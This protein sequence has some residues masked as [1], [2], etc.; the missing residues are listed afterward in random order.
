MYADVLGG[1]HRQGRVPRVRSVGAVLRMVLVALTAIGAAN[2]CFVSVAHAQNPILTANA[3]GSLYPMAYIDEAT[4]PLYPLAPYPLWAWQDARACL[5]EHGY[6]PRSA[7]VQMP[8]LRVVP[9]A[10]TFRVH[11]LTI[12]SLA[13]SMDTT[14]M[15]SGFGAPTIGYSLLHSDVVIITSAYATNLRVL[16]HEAIHFWLWRTKKLLGHPDPQFQV[17]DRDRDVP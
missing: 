1:D 16:R 4:L 15:G 7:K 9:W 5:V 14:S 2:T 3:D 11:D 13:R 6:I 17:C 10:N 8:E 12:D